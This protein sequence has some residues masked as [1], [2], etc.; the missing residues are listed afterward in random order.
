MDRKQI[1]KA[2]K[3]VEAKR[4]RDLQLERVAAEEASAQAHER[5][6]FA[7]ARPQDTVSPRAKNSG[8][9]KKTADKWNQ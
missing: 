5:Q 8:H 7:H 2:R 6:L 1:E 3:A 9:G 4:L